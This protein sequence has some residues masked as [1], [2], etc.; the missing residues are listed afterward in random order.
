[1]VLDGAD[2]AG[3]IP[4]LMHEVDLF[5]SLSEPSGEG[6]WHHLH[7]KFTNVHDSFILELT[8]DTILLGWLP[9]GNFHWK[10]DDL[11]ARL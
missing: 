1:M 10:G 2:I 5:G 11:A 4:Q 6:E 8:V 3:Y 9:G 7:A